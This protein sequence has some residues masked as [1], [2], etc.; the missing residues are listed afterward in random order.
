MFHNSHTAISIVHV[1]LGLF[2]ITLDV[3]LQPTVQY[4]VAEP[5]WHQIRD[6]KSIYGLR[7][8]PDSD[9]GKFAVVVQN[10]LRSLQ[11]KVHCIR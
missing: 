1:V 5:M 3:T 7:L 10:T 4:V 9:G 2:Q 8:S 11:G 6:T